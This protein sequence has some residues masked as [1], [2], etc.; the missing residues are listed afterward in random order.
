MEK[1]ITL[2]DCFPLYGYDSGICISKEK[3]CYGIAYKLEIPEIYSLSEKDYINISNLEESIYK[4]AGE[5]V[6]LHT[7]YCFFEENYVLNKDRAQIDFLNEAN[8]RHFNGRVFRNLE[9]Y[10]YI[11]KAPSNYINFNPKKS[12]NYIFKKRDSF[13]GSIFHENFYNNEQI[14]DFQKKCNSIFNLIDRSKYYNIH[15][16]SFDDLFKKDGLYHKIYNL[17]STGSFQD[18]DFS[19]GKIATGS[20]VAKFYSIQNL[21]QFNQEDFNKY[22]INESLSSDRNK[23]FVSNLFELGFQLKGEHILNKYVYIPNQENILNVI[24]KKHKYF[25]K[26]IDDN[27]PYDFNLIY[28]EN[29]EEFKIDVIKNHKLITLTGVNLCVI[30]NDEGQLKLNLQEAESQLSKINI[31]PNCNIIERKNLFFGMLPCNAIGLPVNNY[32]PMSSD[33]SASLSYNEGGYRDKKTGVEGLRLVDRYGRPLLVSVYKEPLD[34]GWIYNRGTLIAS[35]SG[36][37]KSYVTNHYIPS[38]L[39]IG[40]EIMIME[41]GNSYDKVV[42]LFGGVVVENDD[43]NPFTF[44]PFTL[45]NYDFITNELGEKTLTENKKVK[46]NTIL[47]VISGGNNED[48]KLNFEIKKTIQESM[49][50]KYYNHMWSTENDNFKFNSFFEYLREV[51]PSYVKENKI[52]KERF[53]VDAYIF[54]LSNFYKGNSREHL[55]NSNDPRLDKLSDEKLVYFKL[56]GIIDN[57]F[58]FPVVS[59]MIMDIFNKKLHNK[60]KRAVNKILISDEAWK[61]IAN[62]NMEDYFN[63][64]SRTARKYGGQP[65]FISQKIQDFFAS[66]VIKET[67]VV[68]SHIK[69]FL[70]LSEFAEKFQDIQIPMGL[71]DKQKNLIL[72]N[73]KDLPKDRKLREIAFCWKDK[74]KVYGVETSLEEKCI[75]ETDPVQSSKINKIYKQNKDWCYTSKI[76]A[77]KFQ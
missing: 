59:L 40:S 9:V 4:L 77:E 36:G 68:N 37:G 73:N 10:F 65:V 55:L 63:D 44:N 76:Y 5:D 39:R 31:E 74:I 1:N 2:S 47:N 62:P 17:N 29:I 30:G 7:Q 21:E 48:V 54:L 3:G 8:E 14:E 28:K 51:L 22:S 43:D 25:R 26:F 19:N 18:I 66:E 71:T 33:I 11:L 61:V 53:D 35:G 72:S 6:V 12:N 75:Y 69:I 38:E 45:D 27:N 15:K 46:L 16:L 32:M 41:D 60:G 56:G 13:L 24:N 23:L 67:I 42:D 64:Q 70:D 58:L 52:T 34:K 57:E 50:I 49:I 20:K